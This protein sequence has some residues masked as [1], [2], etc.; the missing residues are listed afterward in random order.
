[1]WEGVG[2]NGVGRKV[3]DALRLAL[4]YKSRI[5]VT[6]RILR[7]KRHYFFALKVSFRMHLEIVF[8]SVF[9]LD[10]VIKSN[11]N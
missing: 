2:G 7:T 4:G 9:R 5:L 11:R 8:I 10:L 6:L 3:G 1:M